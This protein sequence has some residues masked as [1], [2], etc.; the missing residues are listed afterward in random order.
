LIEG[1]K[2]S[3]AQS[4]SFKAAASK[5]EADARDASTQLEVLRHR[6]LTEISHLQ[7]SM[8]T[9]ELQH[10]EEIAAAVTKEVSLVKEKAEVRR[11]LCFSCRSTPIVE[12]RKWLEIVPVDVQIQTLFQ[13]A[14]PPHC[15]LFNYVVL[16]A[17]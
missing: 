9:Q 1:I 8:V 16:G 7:S 4:R 10:K 5:A 13:W 15:P 6:H 2:D 11:F 12:I 17:G 3:R 14:H